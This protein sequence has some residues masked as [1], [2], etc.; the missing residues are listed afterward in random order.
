MRIDLIYF[1][2]GG[3]HRAAAE[4]L[5]EVMQREGRWEPRLGICKR[6]SSIDPLLRLTGKRMQDSYN[7]M[8]RTG[9]HSVRRCFFEHCMV[10]YAP[11]IPRDP[12]C[13]K[14][15]GGS[16]RRTWRLSLV[17]NFNRTLKE[18]FERAPRPACLS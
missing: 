14:S 5:R 15:S 1:D 6:Y 11:C 13:L 12:F 16:R 7:D 17:P 9:T 18:G 4:A 10:W 2:A 3:G 8:L